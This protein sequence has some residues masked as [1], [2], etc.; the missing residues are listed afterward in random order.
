[1]ACIL[2]ETVCQGREREKRRGVHGMLR[3]LVRSSWA[4]WYHHTPFFAFAKQFV[5]KNIGGKEELRNRAFVKDVYKGHRT[6]I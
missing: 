1:M 5:R 3:G 4:A 2:Q 6:E